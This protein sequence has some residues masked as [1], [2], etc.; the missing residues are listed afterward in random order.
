MDSYTLDA[1]G[2]LH[3]LV[4]ALPRAA[5]DLVQRAIA[6]ELILQMPAIAAAES[7]YIVRN[8]DRIAGHPITGGPDDVMAGL[9]GFFPVTVVASDLAELRTMVEWTNAFPRQLHDA[10]VVASHGVNETEA[11][12]TSDEQIADHIPVI[13]E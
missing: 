5:D 3:Y 6:G 8:R 12:V 2:L 10:L 1:S 11:V 9:E 4:D 7:L 13:W